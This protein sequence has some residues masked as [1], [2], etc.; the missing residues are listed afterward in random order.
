VTD[1]RLPLEIVVSF[2]PPEVDEAGAV[3]V[4]VTRRWFGQDA[5]R[6]TAAWAETL[7]ATR[8]VEHPRI[9]RVLM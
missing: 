1:L 8:I 2:P 4:T 7:P 9:A 3:V 5:A 6:W